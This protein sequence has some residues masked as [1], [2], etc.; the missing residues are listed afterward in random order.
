[1]LHTTEMGMCVCPPLI[2]L[3]VSNT[4][5]NADA[6]GLDASKEKRRS[7]PDKLARRGAD[8]KWVPS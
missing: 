8:G 2:W 4:A 6:P 3:T 7:A 1:M 5:A